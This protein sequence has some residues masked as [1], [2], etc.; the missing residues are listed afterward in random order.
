MFRAKTP[1]FHPKLVNRGKDIKTLN[2]RR[3]NIT[4]SPPWLRAYRPCL[5]FRGQKLQAA[6]LKAQG[7]NFLPVKDILHNTT[8]SI[9][10]L[11][12]FTTGTTQC[13][14]PG[15]CPEGPIS[16][17]PTLWPPPKSGHLQKRHTGILSSPETSPAVPY[18]DAQGPERSLLSDISRPRS[19][20]GSPQRLSSSPLCFNSF[21]Y[22]LKLTCPLPY[23]LGDPIILDPAL[24]PSATQALGQGTATGLLCAQLKMSSRP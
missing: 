4:G 6:S 14:D 13:A 1:K 11:P 3:N 23:L 16:S 22:Y 5:C 10:T 24:T 18:L 9:Q 19:T 8:S 20:H 2:N 15:T 21:N 17:T 7:L 12:L